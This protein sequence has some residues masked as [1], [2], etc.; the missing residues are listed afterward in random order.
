MKIGPRDVKELSFVST[1]ILVGAIINA[2]IFG[3]LA[4]IIQDL[5][6]KSMKF[7]EKIDIAN[8]AMKKNLKI[9]KELH[10]KVINY[11]LYT[12]SNRDHQKELEQFKDMISPSLQSEV[13]LFIFGAIVK[14]ENAINYVTEKSF[15]PEDLIM[16]QGD[17]PDNLYFL[18]KGECEVMVK[19]ENNIESSVSILR[20]GD[21]FG[22]IALVSD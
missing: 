22:E 14:I 21:M 17:D 12:Q 10:L 3:N 19:D 4:V 5:K 7:Q 11:L 16:K 1:T 6:K 8:T 15:L 20:S 9:N 13:N 18:Y 2:Y